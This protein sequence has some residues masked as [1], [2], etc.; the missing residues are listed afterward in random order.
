[1]LIQ[2]QSKNYFLIGSKSPPFVTVK[3]SLSRCKIGQISMQ[4]YWHADLN[5]SMNNSEFYGEDF[6]LSDIS[7]DSIF[8]ERRRHAICYL[9]ELMEKS[10]GNAREFF[11]I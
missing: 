11:L 3:L 9:F 5:K 10:F 7:Q 1:M 4:N 8:L 6:D 2:H